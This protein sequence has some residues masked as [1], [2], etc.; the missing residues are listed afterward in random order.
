M[1]QS[2]MFILKDERKSASQS[3]VKRHQSLTLIVLLPEKLID[4]SP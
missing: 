4:I 1:G 2:L 3:G